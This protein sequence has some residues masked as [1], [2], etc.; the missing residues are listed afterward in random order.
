LVSSLDGLAE[1]AHLVVAKGREAVDRFEICVES[2][3]PA[4][5]AV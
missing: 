2:L 5:T 1:L 3:V 4:H